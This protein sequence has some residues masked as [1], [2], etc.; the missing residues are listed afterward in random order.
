MHGNLAA[1]RSQD[2]L[3]AD[4]LQGNENAELADAVAGQRCGCIGSNDAVLDFEGCKR[5]SAMF[6]P[7]V[8]IRVL[9]R[10]GDRLAGCRV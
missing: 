3:V 1:D 9:D 4:R 7:I 10:V 8:A 5:R 2:G 6:S